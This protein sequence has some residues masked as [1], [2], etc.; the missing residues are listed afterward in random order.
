MYVWVCVSVYEYVCEWVFVWMNVCMCVL[1][2]SGEAWLWPQ[3]S[4]GRSMGTDQWAIHPT[5]N[6][7]LSQVIIDLWLLQELCGLTSLC[8]EM[9]PE[10]NSLQSPQAPFTFHYFYFFSCFLILYHCTAH[11]WSISQLESSLV[12]QH[13]PCTPVSR[14]QYPCTPIPEGATLIC[15]SMK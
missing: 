7:L 6:S 10:A 9:W 8:N 3:P 14:R 5:I 4:K 15:A 12:L 1:C 13:K 2:C 11:C